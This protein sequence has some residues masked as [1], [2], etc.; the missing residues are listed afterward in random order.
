MGFKGSEVQI[1]SPVNP[2]FA[3]PP[4]NRGMLQVGQFWMPIRAKGGSLL[5]ADLQFGH[6]HGTTTG[7]M[8]ERFGRL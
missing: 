8:N 1:L 6:P 3:I 4:Q 7:P 2:P 5:H